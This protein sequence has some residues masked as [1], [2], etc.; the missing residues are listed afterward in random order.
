MYIYRWIF[1]NTYFLDNGKDAVY[2]CGNSL[3]VQPKLAAQQV[4]EELQVWSQRGVD[5]HFDHPKGRP[6]KDMDE[7]SCQLLMPL[8]GAAKESEI[9]CMGNLSTNLH[10]LMAAF[11]KPT[12]E[13]FKILIEDGA[14]PS[15]YVFRNHFFLIFDLWPPVVYS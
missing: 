11:Y 10:L 4:E 14:F 1:H 7:E 15:D 13:R 2:V 12:E 5:A 3:G 8:I 6:W 9:A